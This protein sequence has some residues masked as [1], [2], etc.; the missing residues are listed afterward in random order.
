MT[1]QIEKRNV[2]VEYCPTNVM[3]GDYMSKPLQGTKFRT[4]QKDIMGN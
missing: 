2:E 1:D 4:F 3:T